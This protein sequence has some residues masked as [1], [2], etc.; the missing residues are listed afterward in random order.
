M[1]DFLMDVK[2]GQL[3]EAFSRELKFFV[4]IAK[5]TKADKQ[6]LVSERCQVACFLPLWTAGE[7]TAEAMAP[8]N[9][10]CRMSSREI[11]GKETRD[12]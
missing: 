10:H 12:S 2:D 7:R 9:L 4:N 6:V 1:L 11:S 3:A 5:K 8:Q